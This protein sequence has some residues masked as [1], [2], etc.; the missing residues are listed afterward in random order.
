MSLIADSAPVEGKPFSGFPAQA[1]GVA[2]P[3][4]FFSEVLPQVQDLAELRVCLHLFWKLGQARRYP[5]FVTYDELAADPVLQAGLGKAQ[6]S[7]ALELAVARGTLLA[8]DV[9][10]DEVSR[11]LYLVNDASSRR[12]ADRVA[13]GELALEL[14]GGTAALPPAPSVPGQPPASIFSLYEQNI[15]LLT[16]MVV[17]ELAEAEKKYPAAWIGEAFREAV[18]LNKRNWRY[19]HRI[20]E[21]WA[22]EGKDHGEV[23]RYPETGRA[24]RPAQ[25]RPR[26]PYWG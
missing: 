26:H 15:G 22:T 13:R 19:I 10:R 16:P 21:R 4:L 14:P 7:V 5:R 6:L 9:E 12:A 8:L 17:E 23:G 18:S 25:G 11:R 20:L 1:Q 24:R 3:S 2:I